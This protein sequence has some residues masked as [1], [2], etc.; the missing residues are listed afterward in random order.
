MNEK[1]QGSSEITDS[2]LGEA[3][4]IVVQRVTQML[5]DC[6]EYTSRLNASRDWNYTELCLKLKTMLAMMR[7]LSSYIDVMT[8]NGSSSN[9]S[10]TGSNSTQKQSCP[11]HYKTSDDF[12][13]IDFVDR[14]LLELDSSDRRLTPI[15]SYCIMNALKYAIRAG[16]K[17][18]WTQDAYK[19]ADYLKRALDGR[20]LKNDEG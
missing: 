12:E 7:D 4:S 14:V 2:T 8:A 20:W 17:G 15:E 13:S 18:P 19:C 16:K 9:L 6:Q 11:T 10:E 3:S 1:L 5:S